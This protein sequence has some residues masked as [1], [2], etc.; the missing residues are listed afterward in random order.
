MEGFRPFAPNQTVF[1]ADTRRALDTQEPRALVFVVPDFMGTQLKDN[2]GTIW[3]SLSGSAK[4]GL[5]RLADVSDEVRTGD[6]VP[7]LYAP[8]VNR[9]Q[10]HFRVEPVGYDWRK[11]L[12]EI[13]NVLAEQVASLP[14]RSSFWTTSDPFG[15]PRCG[16]PRPST[17]RPG[18]AFLGSDRGPQRQDSAP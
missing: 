7:E 16:C 14:R 6:L 2:I 5:D 12:D 17:A 11:G 15:R 10:Q 8:M 18:S 13:K 9:L 3:P 1:V 4:G